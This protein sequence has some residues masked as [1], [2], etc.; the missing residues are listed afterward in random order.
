[1]YAKY[2]LN[3]QCHL[4]DPKR[5]TCLLSTKCFE[6]LNMRKWSVNTICILKMIQKVSV[7]QRTRHCKWSNVC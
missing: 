4:E 1:M 3:L 7:E 2:V 6:C 5:Y